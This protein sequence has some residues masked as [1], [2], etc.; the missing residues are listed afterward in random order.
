MKVRERVE[1]SYVFG[2]QC[3][4]HSQANSDNFAIKLC[5]KRAKASTLYA[6]GKRAL[7]LMKL[8]RIRSR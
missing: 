5:P 7:T 4:I 8:V 2:I 1:R 3:C 6:I